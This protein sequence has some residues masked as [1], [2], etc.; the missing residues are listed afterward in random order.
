MNGAFRRSCPRLGDAPPRGRTERVGRPVADPRPD[1]GG[2]DD[3][4]QRRDVLVDD[5][6]KALRFY[7]EV[8]G[9]VKKT[10]SLWEK[11]GG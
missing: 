4:N 1:Q 9:L 3:E 8:L 6:D 2:T 11:P 7:T 5:Q 10:E